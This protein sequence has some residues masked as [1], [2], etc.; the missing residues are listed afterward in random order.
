MQSLE[1]VRQIDDVWTGIGFGNRRAPNVTEATLLDNLSLQQ[2][3][4]TNELRYL[5]ERR[6]D[7]CIALQI[8]CGRVDAAC[9]QRRS[10][11]DECPCTPPQVVNGQR[12]LPEI[13]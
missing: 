7:A 8:A 9:A 10:G 3:T 11:V 13:F 5:T 6:S 2:E 4:V 1:I 12:V